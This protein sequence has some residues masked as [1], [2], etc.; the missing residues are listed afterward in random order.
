MERTAG[1][2]AERTAGEE[3]DGV[4]VVDDDSHVCLGFCGREGKLC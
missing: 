3:A 4:P 1:E 2:E